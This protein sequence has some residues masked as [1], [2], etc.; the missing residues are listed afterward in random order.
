MSRRCVSAIAAVAVIVAAAAADPFSAPASAGD[1]QIAESLVKSGKQSLQKGDAAA[2]ATFF[3]RATEE[4]AEYTEA[5]WWWAHAAEKG[6]DKA[7][8][9]GGYRAFLEKVSA[10]AAAGSASKEELRLRGLAEKSIASLAAGERELARAEDALVAALLAF[11]KENFLRD[12]GMSRRA[13]RHVFTVA[14]NHEEA[15]KLAAKLG[16]DEAQEKPGVPAAGEIPAPLREIKE[17]TD[18]IATRGL[19]SKGYTSFEGSFMRCDF[20]DGSLVT[21]GRSIDVGSDFGFEVEFNITKTY[22]G[23]W[24]IGLAVGFRK[25][26]PAFIPLVTPSR[27]VV[28]R[29]NLATG[30]KE[31]VAQREVENVETGKWHRLSVMLRKEKLTVWLDGVEMI[32]HEHTEPIVGEIGFYQQMCMSD[33]RLLRVGR[34]K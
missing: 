3:R 4:D 10:K 21:P 31:D 19:S 24:N 23:D 11:A 17:W 26:S 14:P 13:L 22:P 32:Q 33:V 6:E 12:P 27:V 34:F 9:L 7:A 29:P 18:L 25:S 2:A 30:A 8:A 1:R 5:W 20:P 28:F 16:M 15:R